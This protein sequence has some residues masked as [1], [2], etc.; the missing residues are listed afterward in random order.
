LFGVLV[1]LSQM[2]VSLGPLLAGL[3][4]AGF[5]VGFALQETLSNFAS[6]VM[7]LFYEPFDVGDAVEAGGVLGKVSHMSLVSTTILTFDNQTLIVPNRMIWGNVIKN[8]NTQIQR[9]VDLTFGISYSDDIPRAEA[10]LMEIVKAHPKVLPDPEPVVRLHELGDSS[11]NFVVRPWVL[12][13]DYWDVYW[14]VTR[15]VKM[16]FDEVGISIPFPQRDVHLYTE[17]PAETADA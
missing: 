13:T 10:L 7:I 14:D 12:T 16:R 9:R 5:I 3:G 2:G 4:V 8:I 1:A 17:R 11:V 15:T 6:G